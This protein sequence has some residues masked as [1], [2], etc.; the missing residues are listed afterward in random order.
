MDP[1]NA[2]GMEFLESNDDVQV[3]EVPPQDIVSTTAAL[4]SALANV[5]TIWI[6]LR[7]VDLRTRS[8]LYLVNCCV[9]NF[10]IMLLVPL[11]LNLL[12]MTDELTYECMCLWE[13]SLY[14]M[15]FGNLLF[16]L[17][18]LLDW[19]FVKHVRK[20]ILIIFA[21]WLLILSISTAS[22]SFCILGL[23]YPIALLCSAI[24]FLI[25]G[26]TVVI[27]HLLRIIKIA[28]LKQKEGSKTGLII[29]TAYFLCWLPNAVITYGQGYF[30]FSIDIMVE[31]LTFVLTYSQAWIMLILLFACDKSFRMYVRKIFGCEA[32]DVNPENLDKEQNVVLL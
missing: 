27:T 5:L 20:N 17:I 32:R 30:R 18:L 31:H 23:S 14:G 15:Q 16:A 9:C 8:N 19:Q 25:L 24:T 6:I 2:T 21:A 1:A 22:T 7:Y 28:L 13:E 4:I 29:I 12:G 26:V 3:I 10:G 11:S